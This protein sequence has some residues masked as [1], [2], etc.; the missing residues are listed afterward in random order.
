MTRGAAC[1]TTTA[2]QISLH[3][4]KSMVPWMVEG[5]IEC[6]RQ[7]W[8]VYYWASV[9][10]P[11]ISCTRAVSICNAYCKSG[12]CTN[13]VNLVRA[14]TNS[15]DL[16]SVAHGMMTEIRLNGSNPEKVS[17]VPTH[18]TTYMYLATQADCC[19]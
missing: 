19:G 2:G 1:T 8:R 5:V 6:T 17:Y 4:G 16:Y 3:R 14:I 15:L 11:H 7:I 12:C 9:S 10:K 18:F 13:T